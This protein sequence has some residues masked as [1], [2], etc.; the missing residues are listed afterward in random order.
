MSTPTNTDATT[1]K[2]NH[3]RTWRLVTPGEKI[4]ETD[5]FWRVTEWSWR[6]VTEAVAGVDVGSTVNFGHPPLRRPLSQPTAKQPEPWKLPE[7]PAGQEWHRTDWTQEMLPEGW[8]PLLQGEK[9]KAGDEW[10]SWTSL[11]LPKWTPAA[12]DHISF[13]S[14]H[15]RT[16]R[17]LPQPADPVGIEEV[18]A[19]RDQL[20][21]NLEESKRRHEVTIHDFN[22]TSHLL[23]EAYKEAEGLKAARNECERQ[24]Q[25]KVDEIGRLQST[26]TTVWKERDSA[27]AKLASFQ[28]KPVVEGMPTKSDADQHGDI[29]GLYENGHKCVAPWNMPGVNFVAWMPLP[30]APAE[31]ETAEQKMRREFEAYIHRDTNYSRKQDD[32]GKYILPVENLW[33][34]WQ[35][36]LAS[37]N[38]KA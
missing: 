3:H 19:E 26:Y 31:T 23:R 9:C 4:Q 12:L 15:S 22:H 34:A 8:R 36:A 16:R 7:P 24:H 6:P 2:F 25:E 30:P 17:P 11:G 37:R 35:A 32:L 13:P 33:L 14:S 29:L 38:T 27:L 5:Q 28:W 1:V 18:K 21:A 20:R 10:A